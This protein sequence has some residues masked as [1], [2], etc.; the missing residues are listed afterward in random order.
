MP[1]N[2]NEPL[3]MLQRFAEG[4]EYARLLDQAAEIQD[5]SEQMAYICAYAMSYFSNT[6]FRINKP[7][8][9][10]LGETFEIDR[11]FE[12]EGYRL[13]IE[14]TSH[15]PPAASI[16][17]ESRKGW[18]VWNHVTLTSKFR[19]NY[20]SCFP[21][22]LT[23]IYFPKSGN[24]YTVDSITTTAHNIIVGKMWMDNS[25]DQHIINH[26]T[27]DYCVL[28]YHPYTYFS[29]DPP[30]R[31]TGVIIDGKNKN[32]RYVLNGDWDVKMSMKQIK[33]GA[34]KPKN[35]KSGP[36]YQTIGNPVVLWKK[37]PVAEDAAKR[38]NFTKTT[39][40]L[41]QLEQNIAP[42]DSRHRPDQR[43]METGHWDEA[44]EV[45]K[46]LEEAQ[47]KRRREL[48]AKSK[49][50]LSQGL[51][52]ESYKATWF[53]KISEIELDF[54]EEQGLIFNLTKKGLSNYKKIVESNKKS[55]SDK[56]GMATDLSA[57]VEIGEFFI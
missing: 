32:A 10:L 22:G 48:E 47:R 54:P 49:L 5:S 55:S 34:P 4:I 13:I 17:I 45:K 28:K 9:P 35:T 6:R 21:I 39:F 20:L 46:L 12:E 37:D 44:N 52:P 36:Q 16:F 56:D 11:Y 40:T 57:G 24:H 38:Y 15:H 26:K 31:V 18:I 25:G 14:Q 3:S 8:N 27:N 41:N 1:V 33:P 30:R 50:A 51:E 53:R 43:L 29:R 23:N 2:F 7:F 19:G 42:T